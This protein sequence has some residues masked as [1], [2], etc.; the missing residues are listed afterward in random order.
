M[1]VPQTAVAA[2]RIE[3]SPVSMWSWPQAISVNGTTLLRHPITRSAA[4][5]RAARGIFRPRTATTAQRASAAQVTRCA[6]EVRT[7]TSSS[8]VRMARKE[9]PQRSERRRS[10]LQ[11][12]EVR[13]VCV[14]R[15]PTGARASGDPDPAGT[16]GG[17]VRPPP[18]WCQKR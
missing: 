3:A 9:P 4:Q 8:A 5:T 2:F 14:M 17:A 16:A 11:A 7:G 15:R 1:S 18:S 13:E 6:T 10:S 12:R